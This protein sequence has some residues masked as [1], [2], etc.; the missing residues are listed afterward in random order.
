[1][2]QA[3]IDSLI[4]LSQLSP[5]I[6]SIYTLDVNVHN[7]LPAGIHQRR[8]NGRMRGPAPRNGIPNL[9]NLQPTSSL[10]LLQRPPP[11]RAPRADLPT[12]PLRIHRV[13]LPPEHRLHAP[14]APR[15][16]AHL[17]HL[18][19]HLQAHLPRDRAHSC[20]QQVACLLA[21]RGPYSIAVF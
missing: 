21:L 11:T 4:S 17:N 5:F 8:P 1:M 20:A 19:T 15:Q 14:R 16:E 18:A 7:G 13:S 3:T 2:S 10:P 12:R 6:S 9:L